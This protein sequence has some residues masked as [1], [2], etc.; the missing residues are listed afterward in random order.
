MIA[1]KDPNNLPWYVSHAMYWA[2]SVLLLSW[3]LRVVIE[4]KTAHLH[5]HIH[6]LFGSNYLEGEGHA[7]EAG[8]LSR[9]S[10]MNSAEL[11]MSI[12]NNN[13]I[14]PSYSEAVL[15]G[16]DDGDD[17][18]DS[19]SLLQRQRTGYG[20]IKK[21]AASGKLCRSLT[22]AT[23]AVRSSLA[24]ATGG[25]GSSS[26]RASN[27]PA[28]TM[29][30]VKRFRSCG[31][32]AK[33]D[34][35]EEAPGPG[36]VRQQVQQLLR[37]RGRLQRNKGRSS[38]SV[39]GL[40]LSNGRAAR[41]SVGTPGTPDD[42][43]ISPTFSTYS[44]ISC[45]PG[46]GQGDVDPTSSNDNS[47]RSDFYRSNRGSRG[48]VR[49]HSVALDS[50]VHRIATNNDIA[51][52][53]D[54]VVTGR[55]VSSS[56]DVY[57]SGDNSSRTVEIGRDSRRRRNAPLPFSRENSVNFERVV[58]QVVPSPTSPASPPQYENAIMMKPISSSSRTENNGTA[59]PSD[60][61]SAI[62]LSGAPRRDLRRSNGRLFNSPVPM[63]DS[64]PIERPRSE[65]S[66]H[67][68]TAAAR[69][70]SQHALSSNLSPTFQAY[71]FI[72]QQ[73]QPQPQHTIHEA[74]Q[75]H[76][77]QYLPHQ[78]QDKQ[79]ENQQ[80]HDQQKHHQKQK[81]KL[82]HQQ[83]QQEQQQITPTPVATLKA[84]PKVS[85]TVCAESDDSDS[86]CL[87]SSRPETGRLQNVPFGNEYLSRG[88]RLP[89]S[90]EPRGSIAQSAG[91]LDGP[92]SS[93]SPVLPPHLREG[94]IP[95]TAVSTTAASLASSGRP[96]AGA[97]HQETPV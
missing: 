16:D 89:R 95:S 71:H 87:H 63:D 79:Q 75:S 70:P 40:S 61:T 94:S 29:N 74:Q 68:A 28:V 60:R 73:Y 22:T 26:R 66:V 5:Y 90:A 36:T 23:L 3:P 59:A 4:Y 39:S 54:E 33:A 11:E 44:T 57:L 20:A 34:S 18:D 92:M 96:G 93:Q 80:T 32:F 50:S 30:R 58:A 52:R 9:V 17:E 86:E 69:L 82:R 2:A 43:V 31:T 24:G 14:V 62:R 85:S 45:R 1:F 51:A 10:T 42:R 88:A 49:P 41:F 6:K 81:Q 38:Y 48:Y 55:S 78:K 15:C 91:P 53:S 7:M 72:P 83:E 35:I 13:V 84:L 37:D 65:T 46:S 8:P 77:H 27:T 19:S 21:G 97:G 64:S 25:D 76:D 12:R 47:V 56:G 67:I